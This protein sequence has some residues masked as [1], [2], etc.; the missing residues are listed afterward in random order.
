ML[1]RHAAHFVLEA[2]VQ[3]RDLQDHG[4]RR[5]NDHGQRR[6]NERRLVGQ[7]STGQELSSRVQREPL[8]KRAGL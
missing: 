8:G 5:Q 7:A 4:Q 6:Q 1:L 2:L 3:L